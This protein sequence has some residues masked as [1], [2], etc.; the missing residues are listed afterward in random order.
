VGA[1]FGFSIYASFLSL[2]YLC[3]EGEKSDNFTNVQFWLCFLALISC[4]IVIPFIPMRRAV[5]S[6]E[7]P[8]Y[9]NIC[10][11]TSFWG[12]YLYYQK[13]KSF[14]LYVCFFSFCL[15]FALYKIGFRYWVPFKNDDI[16]EIYVCGIVGSILAA[17]LRKASAT[18][19]WMS[20]GLGKCTLSVFI[21]THVPGTSDEYYLNYTQ[22]YWEEREYH[23]LVA[24]ILF[25]CA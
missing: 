12:V 13:E 6:K 1:F 25:L 2:A 17:L 20:P 10:E 4:N 14:L 7:D 22:I 18:Y 23:K 16:V 3:G 11:E 21:K 9:K 19:S 5:K 8:S 24:L 15:F